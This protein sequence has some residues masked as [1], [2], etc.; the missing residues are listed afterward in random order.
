MYLFSDN[1]NLS[2]I[3]GPN[4]DNPTFFNDLFLVIT[5]LPGYYIMAGDMNCVSDSTK[6]QSTGIDKTHT[7]ARKVIQEFMKDLNLLDVWRD[8]NP[9][10]ISYFCYSGMHQTY[11]HID[12]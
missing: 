2:N 6:D 12:Y 11:S 4:D 8:L 1:I 9:A 5:N 3:Y 7:K 10:A